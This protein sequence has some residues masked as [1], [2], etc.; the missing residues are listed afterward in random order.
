MW[1][2][3]GWGTWFLPRVGMEVVVQ[4]L[5]GDPDQPLVVGCVYNGSNGVPYTLPDDKTKSTIRTRSSP[6]SE[7]FNE[8]RFEDAAGNEEIYVHAQKDHNIEV[9][10]DHTRKVDANETVTVGG[11]RVVTI[12]G[13][14]LVEVKGDPAESKNGDN[15]GGSSFKGSSTA[16]TGDYKCTASATAYISAP[17]SITLECPGSSIKLEPGK[18]TLCAG[19]GATIVLDANA[20]MLSLIHISEPTR[21]Y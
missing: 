2:G 10:N 7:G 17:D 18:I 9:L 1:A 5:D 8:L 14:H 15:T 13:N 4:F 3:A 19:G 11:N 21:P 20:L 16:V 12:Q 6:G